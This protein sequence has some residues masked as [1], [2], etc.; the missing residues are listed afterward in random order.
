M[1]HAHVFVGV[2]N[3]QRKSEEI[4]ES[5]NISTLGLQWLIKRAP[6]LFPHTRVPFSAALKDTNLYQ[7]VFA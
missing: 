5:Q 3:S 2:H 6:L 7:L 1:L 4:K